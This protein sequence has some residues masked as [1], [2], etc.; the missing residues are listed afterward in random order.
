MQPP[1]YEGGGPV[2]VLG[3]GGPS[4]DYA[5]VQ[6]ESLHFKHTVGQAKYLEKPALHRAATM[7]KRIAARLQKRLKTLAAK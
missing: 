3:Y 6:H 1:Q 2:V 7:D 5:I 4:V